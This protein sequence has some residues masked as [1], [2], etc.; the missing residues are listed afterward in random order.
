MYFAAAGAMLFGSVACVA[1]TLFKL[2]PLPFESLFA[3][4]TPLVT[5]NI[6]TGVEKNYFGGKS[7]ELIHCRYTVRD[8]YSDILETSKT[9]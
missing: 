1:A 2:F 3:G 6:R 7:A 9:C 4:F 5:V 8:R